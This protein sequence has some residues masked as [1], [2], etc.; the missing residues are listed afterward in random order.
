[1]IHLDM[2]YLNMIYLNMNIKVKKNKLHLNKR[3]KSNNI[4]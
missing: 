1:M 3:I 2:N 4:Q